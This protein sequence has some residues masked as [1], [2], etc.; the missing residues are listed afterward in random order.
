MTTDSIEFQ[1][2]ECVSDQKETNNR[3]I[4]NRVELFPTCFE[5]LYSKLSARFC[6]DLLMVSLWS[7][8]NSLVWSSIKSVE[9]SQVT[10]AIGTHCLSSSLTHSSAAFPV[11][12]IK[13]KLQTSVRN[14]MKTQVLLPNATNQRHTS[15][16]WTNPNVYHWPEAQKRVIC[17]HWS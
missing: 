11:D 15:L 13:G 17:R 5:V 8:T 14:W 4:Q 7:E 9:N 6:I 3:S 2:K 10:R 1:T 16:D 12:N